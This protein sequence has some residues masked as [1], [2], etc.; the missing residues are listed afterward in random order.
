MLIEFM[1]KLP[2]WPDERS[3]WCECECRWFD[4]WLQNWH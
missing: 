4:P 1:F 2:R 3:V